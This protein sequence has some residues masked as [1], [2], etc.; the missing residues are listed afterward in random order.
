[1][2][3]CILQKG[4]IKFRKTDTISLN[5]YLFIYISKFLA[6]LGLWCFGRTFSSCSKQGLLSSCREQASYWASY[7]ILL[8]WNMR[9]RH[10]CFS[11]CSA[12]TQQFQRAHSR[13]QGLSSCGTQACG[14][15][16]DQDSNSYA[17]HWQA[18][19]YPLHH[20]GS[21][22]DRIS[23]ITHLNYFGRSFKVLWS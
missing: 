3:N 16:P 5:F 23:D 1:M 10:T 8:L 7:G 11:S 22:I 18:D 2:Y 6:T 12:Q 13:A 4:W 21:S 20:Q 9:C 19:S 14:I 17:L 15:F